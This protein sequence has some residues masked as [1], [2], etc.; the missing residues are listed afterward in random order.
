MLIVDNAEST[1][2]F[3]DIND[4]YIPFSIEVLHISE[5]EEMEEIS[6]EDFRRTFNERVKEMEGYLVSR[7]PDYEEE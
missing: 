2:P 3:D 6:A 5:L 1:M 4:D 7:L